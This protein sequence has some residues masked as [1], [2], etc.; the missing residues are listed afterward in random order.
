MPIHQFQAGRR[1]AAVAPGLHG[2]VREHPALA[3]DRL[4]PLR[5]IQMCG[6]TRL[7]PQRRLGLVGEGGVARHPRH[8][9]PLAQKRLVHPHR[10][11]E[12]HHP[13][14]VQILAFQIALELRHVVGADG[15]DVQR[16]QE[17][18]VLGMDARQRAAAFETVIQAAQPHTASE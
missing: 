8:Q 14:G 9:Q 4:H 12:L 13:L 16:F 15:E 6:H 17:A 1:D 7:R 2:F 5:T 11:R 18:D 10:Q 3:H